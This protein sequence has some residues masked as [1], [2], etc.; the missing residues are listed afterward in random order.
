MTLSADTART[1]K[2]D[3][4]SHRLAVGTLRMLAGTA[5]GVVCGVV[6]MVY[7]PRALGKDKYAIVAVVNSII[8]CIEWIGTA[9]LIGALPKFVA[10][11]REEWR[12][13]A[14]SVFLA[15]LVLL[16]LMAGLLFASAPFVARFLGDAT[17]IPY[18]Q[19]FSL[20]IVAR[21]LFY[22][23]QA[24]LLGRKRYERRVLALVAF[25]TAKL[26][27]TILFVSLTHSVY[28]VI[29]GTMMA[30]LTGAIFS[31]AASNVG[32]PGY[33]VPLTPLWRFSWPLVVS[34]SVIWVTRS[35]D[36]WM[37]KR[38]LAESDAVAHYGIAVVM[39]ISLMTVISTAS[40]A[41]LPTL[42]QAFQAGERG[43]FHRLVQKSF[44]LVFL[45][46]AFAIVIYSASAKPWIHLVFG[47]EYLPGWKPAAILLWCSLFG[48]VVGV[49][50]V[51]LVAGNRP[52]MRL[53]IEPPALLILIV[54]GRYL[55]PH[56]GITGAAVSMA[57][58]YGYVAM[59]SL[60][61]TGVLF[62]VSVGY[63]SLIR[64]ALVSV[65]TLFWGRTWEAAGLMVVGKSVVLAMVLLGL[66]Y[67]TTEVRRE[68][69]E[70]VLRV[71]HIPRCR[72]PR[73]KGTAD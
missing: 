1:P 24:V 31:Y 62:G 63:V 45:F 43:R 14:Q 40:Q 32:R 68:D 34:A 10:D 29:A 38:F 28:G 72:R 70:P 47:E 39:Y 20:D 69:F 12:R 19:V 37:V 67:L 55:I 30:S 42:T 71:F 22:V 56:Y 25:W 46:M 51:V 9:V 35:A 18:L 16:S 26:I 54:V 5:F 15:G 6:L 52:K 21:G 50:N 41:V 73:D 60:V 13:L 49:N 11:A 36:I 64:T 3:P 61:I 17:L 33:S 57:L 2:P 65:A 23:F 44:R 58:A 8:I 66:L 4:Q 59:A 48:A 27:F 53:L 7:V